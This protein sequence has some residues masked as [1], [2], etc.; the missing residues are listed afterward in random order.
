MPEQTEFG[1]FVSSKE[2]CQQ[3]KEKKT[4]RKRYL[5]LR[6]RKALATQGNLA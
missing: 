5:S 1:T 3:T 4:Y 6:K 2:D